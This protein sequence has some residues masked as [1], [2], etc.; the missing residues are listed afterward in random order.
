MTKKVAPKEGF[1]MLE[2]RRLALLK[3]IRRVGP[4]IMATATYLKVRC[5]NT[6]CKCAKSKKDRH[7]KLHL[8]WMDAEGAGTCYVPINLRQEVFQWIENY[9]VMKN[10]MI[11]MTLLSRKMIK[12]YSKSH[13]R[14]K[15]T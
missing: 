11:E 12:A 7:E 15:K 2:R 14:A 3:K 6:H 5:G 9:W 4:F 13:P 8:S 1:T 10:L